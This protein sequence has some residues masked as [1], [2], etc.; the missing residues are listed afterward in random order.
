[1][2]QLKYLELNC[3]CMGG[4]TDPEI[5]KIQ[6]ILGVSLL[7]PPSIEILE[8]NGFFG[9]RLPSWLMLDTASMFLPQL[10]QL[11]L[12]GCMLIEQLPPLG[13]LPNLE[14]LEI[15]RAPKINT[16][17]IEFF[18]QSSS[19]PFPKLTTLVFEDMFRWEY[20]EISENYGSTAFPRLQFL[21][22]DHC[23][24]KS[25]PTRIF[26]DSVSLKKLCIKQC[27]NLSE[28]SGFPYVKKLNIINKG[29][30][31][32]VGFSALK[33]LVIEDEELDSLPDWF[34]GA[35][36]KLQKLIMICSFDLLRRCFKEGP[37]WPIVQQIPYVHV[38]SRCTNNY[39]R[40]SPSSYSTGTGSANCLGSYCHDT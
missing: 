3:E 29:L 19:R 33:I 27:R 12:C 34:Y 32:F 22:L 23:S 5:N 16:V 9:S 15:K 8:I 20:W 28:I 37:D 13:M 39:L 24:L 21:E 4:Y 1:M 40:K 6:K 30:P 7:P 36:S 14:H 35:S 38:H 26:F 11:K 25:F 17:G 10:R 2:V 18:G 31:R